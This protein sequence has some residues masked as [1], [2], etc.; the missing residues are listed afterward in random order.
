M[1]RYP[2]LWQKQGDCLRD[3]LDI[4]SASFEDCGITEVSL[5]YKAEK[6]LISILEKLG[7]TLLISREY[8]NFVVALKVVNKKI[9]QTVMPF[10]HPSGIAVDKEKNLIYVASTRNPNQLIELSVS[11]NYGNVLL[12]AR[13]KFYPGRYYFHDLAMINGELYANAVGLNGIIKIDWNSPNAEHLVWFPN[14]IKDMK[15]KPRTEANH[16]QLN[17]IAAGNNLSNSFFSASGDRIK[18]QKPGSVDYPVDKQGVI[19]SGKSREPIAYELTRPHSAKLYK[20]KLYVNNSGYGEFGFVSDKK[21]VPLIK[22]PGWTRGLCLVE[23][24]AF[25]GVSRI[26]P[27]FEHYAPGINEK[28]QQCGI[29]AYSLKDKKVLGSILWEAGNQIFAI[30][31]ISSAICNGFHY[32]STKSDKVKEKDIFKGYR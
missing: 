23:D 7:V 21:F 6:E 30:D 12:P 4:V 18:K 24:I 26:L 17:S 15:G 9:Y 25:I 28:R 11:E 1:S 8:E 32:T 29:Y 19:F 2:V 3:P 10:P 20:K 16:I 31:F 27:R 22:L 5:K 14:C 13:T